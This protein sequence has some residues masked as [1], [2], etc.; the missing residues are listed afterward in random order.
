MLN[1]IVQPV[2]T[3]AGASAAQSAIDTATGALSP[4]VPYIAVGAFLL[5]AFLVIRP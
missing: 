5:V 3:D 1:G 2:A 4:Y